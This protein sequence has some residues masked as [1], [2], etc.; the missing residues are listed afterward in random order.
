MQLN[1]RTILTVGAAFTLF[2]AVLVLGIAASIIGTPI[3]GAYQFARFAKDQEFRT[4]VEDIKHEASFLPGIYIKEG[5]GFT[6][7]FNWELHAYVFMVGPQGLGL[8]G[9]DGS[10]ANEYA[11]VGQVYHYYGDKTEPYFRMESAN[12]LQP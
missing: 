6:T 3:Y 8:Y 4:S 7:G 5:T 1:K 9:D 11:L 10:F 12:P 2:A